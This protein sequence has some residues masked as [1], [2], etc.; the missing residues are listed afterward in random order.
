MQAGLANRRFTFRDVF[1][2]L[3]AIIWIEELKSKPKSEMNFLKYAPKFTDVIL[4]AFDHS[5]A[6]VLTSTSS[7][8]A[9]LVPR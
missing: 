9:A 4:R 3:F 1:T 6:D 7:I 8:M 2:F 5:S